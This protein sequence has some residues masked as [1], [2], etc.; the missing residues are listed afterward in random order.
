MPKYKPE[1]EDEEK[2]HE[3][4]EALATKDPKNRAKLLK[5][6]EDEERHEKALKQ[7][8]GTPKMHKSKVKSQAHKMFGGLYS[9]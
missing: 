9:K 4:Y 5:M 8:N 3:H 6:A 7:M 2:G 1:I